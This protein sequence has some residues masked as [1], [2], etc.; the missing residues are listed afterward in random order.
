MY[1]ARKFVGERNMKELWSQV[2]DGFRIYGTPYYCERR[3]AE[4]LRIADDYI[5]NGSFGS[6]PII[7]L[8]G[9]DETDDDTEDPSA[10]EGVNNS[11][12]EDS[13]DDGNV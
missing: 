13:D 4:A 12:F 3:V 9:D 10:C 5:K 8:T 1:V 11:D 2:L 7:D 6:S